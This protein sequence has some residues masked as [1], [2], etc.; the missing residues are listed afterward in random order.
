MTKFNQAVLAAASSIALFG[1]AMTLIT[2]AAKADTLWKDSFNHNTLGGSGT[3][4]SGEYTQLRDNDIN[5]SSIY[6]ST[7]QDRD[8][9]LYDCNSI[10]TCNSRW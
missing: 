7:I 10:G 1:V 3:Y 9:N 4:N 5:R 2:P 8:G 6:E